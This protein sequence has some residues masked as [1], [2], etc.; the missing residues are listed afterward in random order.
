MF[1]PKL[2]LASTILFLHALGANGMVY[3]SDSISA[4][5]LSDRLNK[6]EAPLI[7]DVRTPAEF[8]QG[9]VPGAI[10]IPVSDIA[11]R[12]SELGAY[13]EKEIV[14]YCAAGPRAGFARSLMSQLGFT[15]LRDL[16]G[17]MQQW[18]GGGYPVEKPQ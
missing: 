13:K 8:S 10:N 12:S 6:N 3:A 11:L 5:E 9:H 16:E 7:L 15:R 18:S 14:V 4:A 2:F 17:H 1:K